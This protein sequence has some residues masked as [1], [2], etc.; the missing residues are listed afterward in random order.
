MDYIIF[1]RIENLN[2]TYNKNE[3]SEIMFLEDKDFKTF[4]RNEEITPWFKIIAETKLEDYYLIQKN[5]L[6]NET[7][8]KIINF[9]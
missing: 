5:K 2:I 6:K 9:C 1:G 4:M 3:V 7:N 8:L